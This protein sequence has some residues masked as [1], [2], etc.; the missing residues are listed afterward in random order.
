MENLIYLSF[1]AEHDRDKINIEQNDDKYIKFETNND[2]L[3]LQ[4]LP[5]GNKRL[6]YLDYNS[7]KG[8]EREIFSDYT[9]KILCEMKDYKKNGKYYEF[10]N[11]GSLKVSTSFNNNVL[12]GFFREYHENGHLKFSVEIIQGNFEGEFKKYNEEGLLEATEIYNKGDLIEK[13]FYY[14]NGNISHTVPFRKKIIHGV[15]KSYLENGILLNETEFVNGVMLFS[16]YYYPETG[17]PYKDI[18]YKDCKF[19]GEYKEYYIN[20]VCKFK[21]FF[22]EG[23]LNGYFV[24]YDIEGNL[25]LKGNYLNGNKHGTFNCYKNNTLIGIEEYKHGILY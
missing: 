18:N 20:Q 23:L 17:T 21:C 3:L 16:R 25:V 8:L 10:Y 6:S 13:S 7:E 15:S 5:N 24:G 9:D 12:D 1:L 11:S 14:K 19:D 4:D 22:K 2:V